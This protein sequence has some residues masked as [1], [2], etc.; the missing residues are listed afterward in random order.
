MLKKI[1]YNQANAR[2]QT[3][4]TT[5]HIIGN[6]IGNIEFIELSSEFVIHQIADRVANNRAATHIQTIAQI[7]IFPKNEP[8]VTSFGALS[9]KETSFFWG[10]LM[11]WMPDCQICDP[12]IGG[13]LPRSVD[14]SVMFS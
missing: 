4:P 9:N 3:K 1:L 7:K 6:K 2:F 5:N 8:N 12:H 10:V 14:D 13:I 11:F